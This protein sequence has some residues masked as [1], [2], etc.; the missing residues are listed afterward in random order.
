[1]TTYDDKPWL[2]FYPDGLSSELEIPD[3]TYADLL[4]EVM[5]ANSD[6]PALYFMG[7]SLT[8]RQL[9]D[10]SARFGAFLSDQGCKPG[11]VVGLPSVTVEP[12][13]VQPP[14]IVGIEPK[15]ERIAR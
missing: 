1:M 9:D 10:L 5:A 7:V 3:R 14:G 8:Y 15:W 11:D 13:T 6:K 4:R 2:K 12:G